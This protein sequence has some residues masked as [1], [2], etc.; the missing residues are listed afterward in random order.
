MRSWTEQSLS[1]SFSLRRRF[2]LQTEISV[3]YI[4]NT[5]CHFSN[6]KGTGTE[7]CPAF[8]SEIVTDNK[9]DDDDDDN[10]NFA[11]QETGFCDRRLRRNKQRIAWIR[12]LQLL[13]QTRVIS[14]LNTIL[15]TVVP[16]IFQ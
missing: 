9:D 6:V 16:K 5:I 2:V 7:M 3:K 10:E 8:V 1:L 11:F 12:S 13:K 4:L 15:Q 14:E